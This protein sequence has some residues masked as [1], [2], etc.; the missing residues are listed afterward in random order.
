MRFRANRAMT[1]A[2]AILA[3]TVFLLY[4]RTLGG[5]FLGDDFANAVLTSSYD[6]H[7]WPGLFFRDVSEGVWGFSLQALRPMAALFAIFE[8]RVFQANPLPYRI[9]SLALHFANAWLVFLLARRWLGAN[10]G[11][12]LA[13]ALLFAIHPIQAEP[14]AWIS[15]Q[16][17]LVPTFFCFAAVVTFFRF[18]EDGK[19]TDAIACVALGFVA[20]FS[21]ENLVVLPLLFAAYDLLQRRDLRGQLSWPNAGKFFSPYVGYAAILVAYFVCRRIAFGGGGGVPPA[22]DAV[23]TIFTTLPL[24]YAEYLNYLCAPLKLRMRVLLGL[25]LVVG[26]VVWLVSA[27]RRDRGEMVRRLLFTGPAWFMITTLPFLLTYSSSRHLYVTSAGFCVFGVLLVKLLVGNRGWVVGA[28]LLAIIAGVWTNTNLRRSEPWIRAGKITRMFH[29]QFAALA[30][31]PPG[32][33]LIINV[34]H[35]YEHAYTLAWSMPFPLDAPFFRPSLRERFNAVTRASCYYR[36]GEWHR[37]TAIARLPELAPPAEAY[38]IDY[39]F[40][41]HRPRVRQLYPARV[42]S[43]GQTIK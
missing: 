39:N 7:R 26:A 29:H 4:R 37:Q 20:I 38:L 25:L 17:D 40:R 14:V 36:P 5:Y 9:T 6:L 30:S 35:N 10:A 22:G 24:R 23:H 41:K 3:L 43:A 32:T 34:P 13:A 18:R 11:Y 1:A 19:S 42:R 8:G 28:L 33:A 15:G 31:A 21:K 2:F 12:S 16:S 27:R